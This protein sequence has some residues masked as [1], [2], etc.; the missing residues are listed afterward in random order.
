MVLG[1]FEVQPWYLPR[2]TLSND[3]PPLVEFR[4]HNLKWGP[5]EYKI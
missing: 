5:S 2:E 1:K 3:K 4:A